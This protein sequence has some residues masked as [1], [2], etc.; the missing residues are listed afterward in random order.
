MIIRKDKGLFKATSK[1]SL[2][3]LSMI[4]FYGIS[5]FLIY[6]LKFPRSI[7]YL[8]DVLNIIS[9][10]YA[11]KS[12]AWNGKININSIF[13]WMWIFIIISIVSS[14]GNMV[15]FVLFLWGIRNNFRYFIFFFS[16]SKLLKKKDIDI[17][18]K[19]VKMAFWVSIPLC[20]YQ[21]LFVS[22][23]QGTIVGDMVGGI[24]YG[25]AGVNSP[26]N[27]L[28]IV[29]VSAI[30]IKYFSNKMSIK[31][32]IIVILAAMYISALAELKV[33]IIELVIIVV[34]VMFWRG[35]SIKTIMISI[36]STVGLSLFISMLV[37]FNGSGKSNYEE[38]LS[39][40]GLINYATKTQGYDGVGDLNRMTAIP[41]LY[42]DFLSKDIFRSLFGIGLGNADY[43]L[44]FSFL[45]SQFYK[46]YNYIHYHYFT[47]PW[48][49]LETGILGLISFCMILL[50]SYFISKKLKKDEREYIQLSKIIALFMI[51]LSFYNTSL[52]GEHSSYLLYMI[53]SI[54][55]AIRNTELKIERIKYD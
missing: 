26:L 29:H 31:N 36:L 14:I 40:S 30:L 24:F 12:S 28:L 18:L 25:F 27:V 41:V 45:Q 7:L 32:L 23:G 10:A 39:L 4:F 53:L 48:I 13:I 50:S 3:L 54:P 42:N 49:F 33:F 37:Y 21:A 5:S 47:A 35:L 22:Y 19:L 17:L 15:P 20:T 1:G 6:T 38:L 8:G 11:I 52:R 55:F 16:C 34:I 9:F 44:G 46:N 2:I 43:S 51:F